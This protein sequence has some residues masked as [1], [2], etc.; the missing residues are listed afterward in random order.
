M[1]K[2]SSYEIDKK[3]LAEVLSRLRNL[4]D[5]AKP[6][7]VKLMNFAAVFT[8]NHARE[9]HFFV[10]VGK[11]SSS[12]AD[13]H[14]FTFKNPDGTPRFKVRTGVLRNSIQHRDAELHGNVAV[15]EVRAGTEY[16]RSVEEGRPGGR[17]FPFLKPA[18][19]AARPHVIRYAK[20]LIKDILRARGKG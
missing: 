10:G 8:A 15:A 16:A 20:L 19:E 6:A 9:N 13:K 14:V 7:A 18:I 11:G 5:D 17:A 12:I 3:S 2:S 4:G 1:A